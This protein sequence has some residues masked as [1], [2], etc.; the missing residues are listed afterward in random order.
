M[1]TA[2]APVPGR[3]APSAVEEGGEA[4]AESDFA[5][6]FSEE[7]VPSAD[8][9]A[10]VEMAL[11]LAGLPTA[12]KPP[13]TAQTDGDDLASE[14]ATVVPRPKSATLACAPPAPAP[15]TPGEGA[16][17]EDSTPPSRES[18]FRLQL[19]DDLVAK[20][21]VP[22][23]TVAA[24]ETVPAPSPHTATADLASAPTIHSGVSLQAPPLS[25]QSEP[26]AS[27]SSSP[28]PPPARQLAEAVSAAMTGSGQTDRIELVLRPEELGRVRFELRSEGDRLVV[29]LTA[30]RP[31]TMD[32]LRRHLPELRVELEQAGFGG[33]SLDFG[34]PGTPG[35][36]GMAGNS[37]ENTDL[38]PLPALLPAAPL[39]PRAMATSGLD[40][41]L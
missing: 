22:A 33:A 28:P 20:P 11:V 25:A 29:T 23:Q 24:P 3:P 15:D 7:E 2:L 4:R 35:G 34:Q 5:A 10:S 38:P 27:P 17:A 18:A 26:T 9:S 31:E 12:P 39:L 36:R 6:Q 30:D 21:A 19:T 37:A 32:L 16:P 40:I 1:I 13:V 14:G 8:A 41:R